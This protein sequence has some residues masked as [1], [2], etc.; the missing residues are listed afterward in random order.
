MFRLYSEEFYQNKS[1]IKKNF[2]DQYVQKLKT[3]HPD[4]F[5]EVESTVK[6]IKVLDCKYG[7]N[8]LPDD[9]TKLLKLSPND[10]SIIYLKYRSNQNF[11]KDLND[12]IYEYKIDANGKREKNKKKQDIIV[13]KKIDYDKFSGSI[14][15]FFKE[16]E[17]NKLLEIKTCFYCN[18]AYINSFFYTKNNELKQTYDLDHF[19]SRDVCPLFALSLYNF[20]PCCQI[21][22]ERIKHDKITFKNITTSQDLQILFPSHRNYMYDKSLKFIITHKLYKNP[23]TFLN[24]NDNFVISFRHKG[25]KAKLYEDEEANQF[26]ILKRYEPHKT[27]FLCYMEKHRNYDKNFK[28]LYLKNFSKH[29]KNQLIEAIFNIK[30]RDNQNMIFNK[31]YKDLD[32]LF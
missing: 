29:E 27:E 11:Q 2:E 13:R 7:I 5:S 17:N 6:K 30:L 24:D 18:M 28:K 1:H 26:D 19:I 32:L 20:V 4:L 14:I 31:I 23:K 22:N 10:M 25:R 15:K 3:E 8:K 21:C 12:L 16:Q 9:A